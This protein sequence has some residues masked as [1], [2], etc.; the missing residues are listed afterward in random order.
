MIEKAI[1][2]EELNINKLGESFK[3][4]AVWTIRKYSDEQQYGLGKA[5]EVAIVDGNILLNEGIN[6]IWS[7]VAGGSGTVFSNANSYLG[8]GDSSTAAA[9]TQT[10][11]QAS[12]NKLYKAVDAS[13]PTYGT[14]Q[15]I[16]FKA[17]FGASDANFSWQEFTVANGNSDSATNLNRK[18][19][20]QGT[21]ASG[22]VWELTLDITLS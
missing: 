12:T 14:D 5:F 17:T 18:V 4:K 9:A 8:V 16:T 13:Y 19:S 2:T 22:Q 6:L 15:K 3:E 21:K 20:D 10:G 11:L 1:T 7:L